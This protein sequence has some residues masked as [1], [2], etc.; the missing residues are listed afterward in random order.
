MFDAPVSEATRATRA[1]ATLATIAEQRG[2]PADLLPRMLAE[3]KDAC[4][5][6]GIG[7]ERREGEALVNIAVTGSFAGLLGTRSA[8]SSSLGGSALLSRNVALA[9]DTRN[10]SRVDRA[11][12]LKSD[13]GTLVAVPVD[14]SGTPAGVL[15][16]GWRHAHGESDTALHILRIGAGLL[17]AV[18]ARTLHADRTED[19][20]RLLATATS[21]TSHREAEQRCHD[22]LDTLTGLLKAGPFETALSASAA[23]WSPSQNSAVLF[24]DLDRFHRVNETHGHAAGDSVLQRV[25]EVLRRCTRGH[26]VVA[27]L[28]DDDFAVLLNRLSNPELQ[29]AVAAERIVDAVLADNLTNDQLPRIELCIG[30]ALIDRAGMNAA[31]VMREAAHALHAEKTERR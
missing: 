23:H 17:A 31:R 19:P 24:I 10:D 12:Y 21:Q 29:A 6:D 4:G 27:R 22:D 13:S 7:F 1:L 3:L 2:R 28:G 14:V 26:D 15:V 20:E 8:V 11:Q 25:A 16:A 18:L 9:S 5:A 30:A